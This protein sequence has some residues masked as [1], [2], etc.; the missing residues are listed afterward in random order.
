MSSDNIKPNLN[1][2]DI[3]KFFGS[4]LIF[5]MHCDSLEDFGDA[6]FVLMV[7]TRWAV[8]F[9]FISSSY[10]LFRNKENEELEKK[11]IK[12]Y[13]HRICM[14]YLLWGIFN[15][16][17]IIYQR[18]Y[19]NGLDDINTYVQFVKNFLIQS[20]FTG[21]WYLISSIFSACFVY[22][23]GKKFR[24]GT[25]IIFSLPIYCICVLTSVY[26]GILPETLHN[27]FRF[28]SFPLNI[29]GG[30]FYFS[31]GKYIAESEDRIKHIFT[32]GKA[33]CLFV[34]FYLLYVIE[35]R[36]A[37][38]FMVFGST[39]VAFSTAILAFMLF[40]F[41]IQSNIHISNG[42]LLRKLSI[43]IY[44]CQANVL[45]VNGFCK[46][47]LVLPS[48]VAFLVSA[49]TVFAISSIVLRIQR[50]N[51]WKWTRYLT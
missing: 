50:I 35:L 45:L 14:L 17:F 4:I 27:I 37:N 36:L 49:I 42:L 12:H 13:V 30:C 23:L 41:C 26:E 3:A 51:S 10:F 21:S 28:L 46:K 15:I 34:L 2:I 24:T 6:Q 16:P 32:R 1:A 47:I 5:A 11:R 38:Y 22:W 9:F 20:T 40:V 44:C 8:P 48:I 29:F 33:I 7:M 25:I 43:I 39:D 19:R 31:L 18:F